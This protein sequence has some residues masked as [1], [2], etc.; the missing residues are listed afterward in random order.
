M[1]GHLPCANFESPIAAPCTL[2]NE[3]DGRAVS[4]SFAVDD[5]HIPVGQIVIRAS[6]GPRRR[7]LEHKVRRMA[8]DPFNL[9]RF[10]QAQA[11]TFDT[12]VAELRDGRKKT[13]WMWYVFPQLRGLGRS[14]TAQFYGIPSLDEAR[15][16]LAHSVL[17]ARLDHATRLALATEDLSVRQIFGAPDDLKF[18]SSMTLFALASSGTGDPFREAL[19]RWFVGEMDDAS[20]LVLNS[21]R[22]CDQ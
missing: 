15:A 8:I 12:A 14:P 18:H 10:V 7:C 2:G 6:S 3:S 1:A 17:G 9:E 22:G 20:L 11:Y 13:H 19:N 21:R 16:F 5:H 4:G